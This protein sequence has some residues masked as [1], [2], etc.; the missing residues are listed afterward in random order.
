MRGQFV[1]VPVASEVPNTVDLRL[2]VEFYSK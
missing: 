2:I 1:N